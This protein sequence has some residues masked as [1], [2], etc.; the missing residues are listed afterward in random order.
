M[1]HV[2]TN[3]ICIAINF[4]INYIFDFIKNCSYHKYFFTNTYYNFLLFF[5]QKNLKNAE[6]FVD[7][8]SG[9]VMVNIQVIFVLLLK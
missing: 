2:C 6:Y 4:S 7:S 9:N 1:Y 3:L 8:N 5:F